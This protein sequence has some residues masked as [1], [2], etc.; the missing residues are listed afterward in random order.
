MKCLFINSP[1]DSLIK[2]NHCELSLGSSWVV[3]G[4]KYHDI[5]VDYFDFNIVL[6]NKNKIL[7]NDDKKIL[8][9]IESTNEFINSPNRNTNIYKWIKYLCRQIKNIDYDFIAISFIKNDI[10]KISQ[11][12]TF[13]FGIILVNEILKRKIVSVYIGG[14]AVLNSNINNLK[15]IKKNNKLINFEIGYDN[16]PINFPKK[17]TNHSKYLNNK[18]LIPPSYNIKNNIKNKY[19]DIFSKNI[20]NKFPIL[21]QIKDF[22]LLPYSFTIEC[23]YNCRFC[24][25]NKKKFYQLPYNQA[26]DNIEKMLDEFNNPYFRFF[27]SNINVSQKYVLNFCNEIVKRNLKITF[28]DSANFKPS[29]STTEVF[30]ALESAGCIKLWFGAESVS[31]KMLKIINK[32]ITPENIKEGLINADKHNIWSSL[33]FIVN[34]PGETNKEFYHTYNFIKKNINLID[35]YQTNIYLLMPNSYIHS[36]PEKFGIKINDLNTLTF[37][38]IAYDDIKNNIKWN[39]LQ[40]IGLEREKILKNISKEQS[41]FFKNDRILFSISQIT[42]NKKYKKEIFKEILK[43]GKY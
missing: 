14:K 24:T 41:E 36:N 18:F 15:K 17:I 12:Y 7:N 29:N 16:E 40:K 9:S 4:L 37:N 32:G 39:Q 11:I 3:G 6:N 26:V 10:Q 21:K 22:V 23:P 13:N 31:T 1:N 35:C 34:M 28:S 25:S 30:S 8:Y 27:N 43:E 2:K 33:N 19:I 42:N 5:D 20:I 38:S